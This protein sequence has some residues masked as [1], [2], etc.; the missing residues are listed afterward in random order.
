MSNFID[1]LKEQIE[2]FGSKI[3]H[4]SDYLVYVDTYK[5]DTKTFA[6]II[7]RKSDG[8]ILQIEFKE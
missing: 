5:L 7:F 1:T 4:R 8:K 2:T 6:N 3:D